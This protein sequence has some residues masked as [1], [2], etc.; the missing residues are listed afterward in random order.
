MGNHNEIAKERA[1]EIIKQAKT[2]AQNTGKRLS[3]DTIKGYGREVSRLLSVANELGVTL[4]HAARQ[5]TSPRT[6]YRRRAAIKSVL[7]GKIQQLLTDLDDIAILSATPQ[8]D[9]AGSLSYSKWQSNIHQIEKLLNILNEMDTGGCPIPESSRAKRSSKK[10]HMRGLPSD[11]REQ[12]IAEAVVHWR[13]PILVLAICGCRPAE[14]KKGIE[15]S[16]VMDLLI[17]RIKGAKVTESSGQPERTLKFTLGNSNLVDSLAAAVV[18]GTSEVKIDNPASLT[19]TI[20]AIGKKLWPNRKHAITA[21]CFRHA[22]SS[23]MKNSELPNDDISAALGHKVSHTKTYYGQRQMAGSNGIV[24]SAV[25][26]TRAIRQTKTHH[27]PWPNPESHKKRK[28][29]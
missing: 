6:W 22:A 9:H 28:T 7:R 18:D 5:T 12:V 29:T 14:I 11:W 13:L 20:R 25:Q 3:E 8:H 19:S 21:Y 24:P 17:C 1:Y 4:I 15:L 10:Q 2:V 23:D 26:A 16:V 27:K